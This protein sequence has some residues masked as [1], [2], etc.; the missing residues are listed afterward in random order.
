MRVNHRQHRR[1]TVD[2]RA[3]IALHACTKVKTKLNH[4]FF[5]KRNRKV[6]TFLTLLSELF[7]GWVRWGIRTFGFLKSWLF[8]ARHDAE[9]GSHLDQ[10]G[11]SSILSQVLDGI[12]MSVKTSST[13][14]NALAPRGGPDHPT[15]AHHEAHRRQ[16][17]QDRQPGTDVTKPCGPV[18][19]HFRGGGRSRSWTKLLR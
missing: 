19:P 6:S 8:E 5:E 3:H 16:V 14:R 10:T 15:G 4:V 12:A 13:L 1:A 18:R 2:R 7:F 17:A 11:V 9:M